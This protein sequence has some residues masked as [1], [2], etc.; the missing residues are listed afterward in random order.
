MPVIT[1]SP[2]PQGYDLGQSP[3]GQFAFEHGGN[4][5]CFMR[6]GGGN[7]PAGDKKLHAFKSTDSGATWTEQDSANAPILTN[8]A[9]FS[10]NYTVALDGSNVLVLDV[11]ASAGSPP[12]ITGL[13]RWTYDLTADTWSGATHDSAILPGYMGRG[14]G[15]VTQV[16]IELAVKGTS[17]YVLL[18]SG[19]TSGSGGSALGRVYVATYNGTTF[20]TPTIVPGQS[21]PTYFF[22]VDIS[23]A[24]V[25]AKFYLSYLKRS[26]TTLNVIAWDEST[27]GS[28]SIVT[29]EV[30]LVN[31]I[32]AFSEIL[33]YTDTVETLGIA[34][35]TL[36]GGTT[37]TEQFFHAPASTLVWVPVTVS[38]D[39]AVLPVD[40]AFYL[41]SRDVTLIL[42]GG[43]LTLVWVYTN[44][45][46][47]TIVFYETDAAI[48]G[49]TWTTP[50][51]LFHSSREADFFSTCQV[52]A[53][54]MT[55]GYG[56]LGQSTGS[57]NPDIDSET[58]D[59]FF[60]GV[61]PPPEPP[62]CSLTATPT[63]IDLPGD[64]VTLSW[65]TT[66]TPTTA[67]IDNGVGTVTPATGGSVVVNP[68]GDVTYTLT[69][70]NDNGS[71][72][73]FA[74]VVVTCATAACVLT[75][76]LVS[77]AQPCELEGS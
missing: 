1:F 11:T 40:Q 62:T 17:D 30:N 45:D 7:S 67:T 41:T 49:S 42:A 8:I 9:S 10:G 14:T 66:G 3:R 5:Y 4:Q 35:F 60:F 39:S 64:P 12:T 77:T 32:G 48:P 74:S 22:P 46:L 53:F 21:D 25:A 61:A 68:T 43:R 24:P 70:S 63:T 31:Q 73:C 15:Q 26:D 59:F 19:P 44:F 71:S 38:N 56:T 18:Y 28:N 52:F 36:V 72:Q 58:M 54:N 16:M 55:G 50:T 65:T 51:I 47:P 29:A 76:A 27:F 57:F 6:Q 34:G 23:Y 13:N 75:P 2:I 33:V 20:G 69:V 37:D